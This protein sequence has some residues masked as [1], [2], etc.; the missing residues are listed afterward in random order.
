MAVN[1]NTS[2][3]KPAA[4]TSTK[5]IYI[6]INSNMLVVTYISQGRYLYITHQINGITTE[7]LLT[8]CKHFLPSII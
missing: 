6:Y 7:F 5:G 3:L 2:P 4:T 8:F 1:L